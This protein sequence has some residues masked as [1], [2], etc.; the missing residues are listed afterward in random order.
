MEHTRKRILCIPAAAEQ[1]DTMLRTAACVC[2]VM[3]K[4]IDTSHE[5]TFI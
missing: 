1:N 2:A 5:N 4:D 3:L